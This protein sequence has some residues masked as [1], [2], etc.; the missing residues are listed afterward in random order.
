[1]RFITGRCRVLRLGWGNPK[2]V[3]RVGEQP[4]GEGL[5]VLVDTS[6]QCMLAAQ[7]ANSI[8]GCINR[9]M[10]AAGE[11]IVLLHSAVLR[12]AWGKTLGT[13]KAKPPAAQPDSQCPCETAAW[14][15]DGLQ[16]HQ[17]QGIVH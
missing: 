13:S 6:Q 3:Y 2:Y 4:C 8:L 10:A 7:K 17:G 9:R 5:Q 12:P 1:M 14:C 15:Q 11:G 16:H